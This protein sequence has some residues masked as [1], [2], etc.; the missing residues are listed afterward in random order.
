MCASEH[1]HVCA[2]ALMVSEVFNSC[3]VCIL[4]V[5]MAAIKELRL[6][7]LGWPFYYTG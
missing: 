2:S 6:S 3:V 4:H 5:A 7:P 1:A